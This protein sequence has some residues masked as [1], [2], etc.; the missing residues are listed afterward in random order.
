M[1]LAWP[2]KQASNAKSLLLVHSETT[3]AAR[4]SDQQVWVTCVEGCS[5]SKKGA[6]ISAQRAVAS[7]RD[8]NKGCYQITRRGATEFIR[9][10]A[11]PNTR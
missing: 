11:T 10:R 3:A 1:L 4:S 8:K 5:R 7:E 6:Q 2:H 9:A